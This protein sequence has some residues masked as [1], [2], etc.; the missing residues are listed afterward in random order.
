MTQ[1]PVR[2]PTAEHPITVTPTEGRVVVR[3][4]GEIVADTQPR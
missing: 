2:Q 3:V 4:D 1:R